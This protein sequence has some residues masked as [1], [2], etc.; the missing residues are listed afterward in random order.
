[1]EPVGN[2]TR[3][4]DT[5]SIIVYPPKKEKYFQSNVCKRYSYEIESYFQ[6]LNVDNYGIICLYIRVKKYQNI[7]KKLLE[8]RI[9]MANIL[10][11]LFVFEKENLIHGYSIWYQN[12][13]KLDNKNHILLQNYPNPNE[14]KNK[15]NL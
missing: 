2:D 11:D 6:K 15:L 4:V 14:F 9:Y 8:Y 7:Y 5:R 10:K 1:M 12:Y 13:M 3:L